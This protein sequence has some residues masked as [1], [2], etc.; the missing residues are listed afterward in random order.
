[1]L[2]YL[3]LL[4]PIPGESSLQKS[5]TLRFAS[6]VFTATSAIYITYKNLIMLTVHS[7]TVKANTDLPSFMLKTICYTSEKTE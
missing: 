2:K 6:P 5:C 7:K 1:M 4:Q 3:N